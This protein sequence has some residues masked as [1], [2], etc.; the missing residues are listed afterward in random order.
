M[1]AIVTSQHAMKAELDNKITE[2]K[3]LLQ[4]APLMQATPSNVG[5]LWEDSASEEGWT[6]SVQLVPKSV[7]L[8][9]GNPVEQFE[10]IQVNLAA[11]PTDTLQIGQTQVQEEL[12]V[13][14]E[15]TYRQN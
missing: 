1:T 5:I 2:L 12:H 7:I 3:T 9:S 6:K 15:N 8:P 4:K 11:I 13:R 14:E 10:F